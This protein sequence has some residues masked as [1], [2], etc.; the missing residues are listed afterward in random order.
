VTLNSSPYCRTR[1]GQS[2]SSSPLCNCGYLLGYSFI[3]SS[4]LK[5]LHQRLPR[6]VVSKIYESRAA[7]TDVRGH[8][9]HLR[10]T[11][12]DHIPPSGL[13]SFSCTASKT[14]LS[15]P[16]HV[17]PMCFP[18]DMFRSRL[19]PSPATGL[20]GLPENGF[21]DDFYGC[22]GFLGIASHE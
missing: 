18:P 10:S 16:P 12:L 1:M 17:L 4:K 5:G 13:V 11:F 7:A 14:R 9:H 21:L 20:V 2:N 6:E 3:V 8:P 19:S 15:P 22:H